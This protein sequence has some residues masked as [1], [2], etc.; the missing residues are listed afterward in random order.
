MARGRPRAGSLD[1]K[2]LADRREQVRLNVR[3]HRQRQKEKKRLE[4]LNQPYEPKFRWVQE[5][6]WQSSGTK[7]SS[8]RVKQARLRKPRRK[9]SPGS[10]CSL[11]WGPS[12]EKQYTLSLLGMFRTRYLPERVTLP[13]AGV[14]EEQLITPCA[15]WVVEAYQMAVVRENPVVTG[16]LRAL[17]LSILATELRREDIR[18]VSL[19]TYHKTLPFICRQL[20]SITS[21]GS[22]D[23]DDYLALILS[24]H[25]AAIFEVNVSGCMSRIFDQVRGLGSVYVHQLLQS[26]SM[27]KDWRYLMEEYRLFEIIFCLI[28]RR[29]SVLTGTGLCRSARQR[30]DVSHRR[31]ASDPG[32]SQ[33]GELVFLARHIPPIMN[34]IDESMVGDALRNRAAE[35]L[36]AT[37]ET[38]SFVLEELRKWCTEFLARDGRAFAESEAYVCGCGD[39]DFPDFQVAS[40]WIFWL[41]FKIHALESYLSVVDIIQSSRQNHEISDLCGHRSNTSSTRVSQF[42]KGMLGARSELLEAVQLLIRSLP[43]LLQANVGYVGRSFVAFPLETARVALLHE[44]QRES[45]VPSPADVLSPSISAGEPTQG[46]L[47]GLASCARTME[48]AKAMKCALFSDQWTSYSTGV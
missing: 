30:N 8:T 28:Y 9:P 20:T 25:A 48:N 39:F 16:M 3:A 32:N 43:Y 15:I 37:M 29:P 36:H 34:H 42:C 26:G 27:P 41:S 19:N 38:V 2:K 13:G 24:G 31:N 40:A 14:S 4:A 46:I 33:F 35:Q 7:D 6:K 10:E 12:P 22:L 11:L 5:T 18:A 1:D 44:L 45:S 21:G 23:P 17:G 47:Q